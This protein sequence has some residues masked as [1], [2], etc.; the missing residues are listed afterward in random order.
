MKIELEKTF[1]LKNIPENLKNYKSKEV[2]DIYIPR[3]A[4]HPI[5]RIRKNGDVF[6]LTKKAPVNKNDA[7]EQSEETII[8]TKEEY[9]YFSTLEG[10]RVRKVRYYY[11]VDN[12]IAEID[13]FLDDLEGL[14]LVDVEFNSVK[15][16]QSF[17]MPDFCLVDVT[18]EK[19]FA[20]GILAGKKYSDIQSHLDKYGYK[21]LI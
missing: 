19:A 5:L 1:L 11:P 18:Q 15:E 9:L 7:S 17:I 6:E 12:K 20:G 14:A 2:L 10:K 21:K 4:E 8:L 16:K 3:S 13:I